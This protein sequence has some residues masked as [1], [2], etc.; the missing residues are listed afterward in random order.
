MEPRHHT[1]ATVRRPF[2]CGLAK[3]P[4]ILLIGNLV[5]IIQPPP[6]LRSMRPPPF[7]VLSPYFLYKITLLIRPVQLP[8][9][10][11]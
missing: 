9:E 5:T 3:N 8:G 1:T 4:P 6:L 2:F 11:A 10:E 7:G